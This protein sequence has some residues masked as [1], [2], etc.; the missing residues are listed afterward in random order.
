MPHMD[1][2]DVMVALSKAVPESITHDVEELDV[3]RDHVKLEGYLTLPAEANEQHPVP[4]VVLAHGG[5]TA[6]DTTDFNP[7]VQFLASRGYAVL[8]PNYRGSAGY[9]PALS[10]DHELDCRRMH[11]DVTDATRAML[12]SPLIDSKRVAIMGGSFG[13]YLA[14][15]GVAF[16][17]GL[18]RCAITAFGIFDWD[19][20]IRSKHYEGRPGEYEA[21]LE[22]IGR[23]GRDRDRLEEISP[24]AHADQIHA[25]VLIAHG[26][27]D[28][29]VDVAQSKKLAAAL[30]KRGV[31]YE[32]F[33]RDVMGHGFRNYQDR[34]DYYHR[35]EAF[36][37]ANL[38]GTSLT[39]TK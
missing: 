2:F 6:R 18:Y 1:G 34:V 35:V 26:T 15:A 38:G 5:P 3:T 17:D 7:E 30:K 39:P 27:E 25:P 23:P 20:F 12:S 10:R 31:P 22:K 9:D 21:L 37:A 33:Y 36:L 32:T 19:R 11:E 14:L 8:Q 28:E 24:L 13:G 16:E 29:I 4:L